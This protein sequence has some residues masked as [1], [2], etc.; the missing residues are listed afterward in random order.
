M[1]FLGNRRGSV[2]PTENFIKKQPRRLQEESYQFKKEEGGGEGD[3][4][5]KKRNKEN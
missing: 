1:P 5:N 2:A 3:S 4:G